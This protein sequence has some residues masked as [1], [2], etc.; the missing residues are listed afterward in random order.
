[1]PMWSSDFRYNFWFVSCQP[2]CRTWRSSRHVWRFLIRR[3]RTVGTTNAGL[4]FIAS[5][6][7]S[8]AWLYNLKLKQFTR[9]YKLSLAIYKKRDNVVWLYNLKLK[10]VTPFYKLS[11]LYGTCVWYIFF[12]KKV[13]TL[14]P[15]FWGCET[16]E[17]ITFIRICYKHQNLH[18]FFIMIYTKMI[19]V[20]N[21][22][23]TTIYIINMIYT[24]I[25]I[26]NI[27]Y[28][29]NHTTTPAWRSRVD[30]SLIS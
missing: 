17:C 7:S 9:F 19:Y 12:T 27:I 11:F 28:T 5:T 10:Q 14:D 29:T 20:I 16:T 1:M 30:S 21:M 24:T 3:A 8:V 13:S 2:F 18:E 26:I 6:I 22:M 23:Y 4:F 15:K 25:Y